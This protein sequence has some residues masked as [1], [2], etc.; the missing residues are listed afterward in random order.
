M[1]ILQAKRQQIQK[2]FDKS[3]LDKQDYEYLLKQMEE[4]RKLI[5]NSTHANTLGSTRITT[6]KIW[7]PS[8]LKR[9][10]KTPGHSYGKGSWKV[11]KFAFSFNF[12]FR[13]V[14]NVDSLL[15]SCVNEAAQL[16]IHEIKSIIMSTLSIQGYENVAKWIESFSSTTNRATTADD[17]QPSKLSQLLCSTQ[18][19][20]AIL[21]ALDRNLPH[22]VNDFDLQEVRRKT[23]EWHSLIELLESQEH[24]LTPLPFLL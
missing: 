11:D 7:N 3:K 9:K 4:V 15:R 21:S 16:V 20:Y 10:K 8:K 12:M 18:E 5:T 1:E 24:L 23:R 22:F 17:G 2:A 13:E 6:S 19:L 14:Y